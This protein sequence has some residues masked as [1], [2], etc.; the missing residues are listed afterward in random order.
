MLAKT[1]EGNIM[2]KKNIIWESYKDPFLSN[3]NDFVPDDNEENLPVPFVDDDFPFSSQKFSINCISSPAGIIPITESN[4]P[5]KVYDFWIAHC[6]FEVSPIIETIVQTTPGVEIY[7]TFSRYRFR[8]AIGKAFDPTEVKVNIQK[9]L[10]GNSKK[11]DLEV[12]KTYLSGKYPYWTIAAKSGE[13]HVHFGANINE[14]QQYFNKYKLNKN[15]AVV[16]SWE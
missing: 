14:I 10:C 4:A 1:N 11:D 13:V 16:S 9:K 5:S 12:M 7:Q 6:N 15:T 3:K 2:P 8:L